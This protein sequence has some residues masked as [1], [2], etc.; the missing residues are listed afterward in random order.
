[1]D[2]FIGLIDYGTQ[3][4]LSDSQLQEILFRIDEVG[5]LVVESI[6]FLAAVLVGVICSLIF[7]N[8]FKE[9]FL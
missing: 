8:V 5:I 2:D 4:I 7:F 9:S 6:H 3:S 1:M